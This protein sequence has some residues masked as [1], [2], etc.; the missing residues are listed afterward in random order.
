MRRVQVDPAF[1]NGQLLFEPSQVVASIPS[2]TSLLRGETSISRTGGRIGRWLIVWNE[3]RSNNTTPQLLCGR[4]LLRDGSFDGPSFV[5][6]DDALTT[7]IS[8]FA[9]DGDGENFLVAYNDGDAVARARCIRRTATGPYVTNSTTVYTGLTGAAVTSVA[10][11]GSSV[12]IGASVSGAPTRRARLY[13]VDSYS[14]VSCEGGFDL[15]GTTQTIDVGI[16]SRFDG[17][18]TSSR[19]AFLAWSGN[20]GFVYEGY[21]QRFR[22]DSGSIQ[23]LG[24]GCGSGGAALVSCSRSPVTAPH[25]LRLRGAAPSAMAY[26]ALSRGSLG[27]ACGGGCQLLADPFDGAVVGL[28][29]DA[30]GDAALNVPIGPGLVGQRFVFQWISPGASCFGGFDL[31]NA[32]QVTIQ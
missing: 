18:N 22:T 19:D 16:G 27:I 28:L 9:V 13:S 14:G 8:S 11:M 23:N 30:L 4:F 29:T 6:E 7:S 15:T 1:Q 32:L 25:Y 31:S 10:W 21:A 12:L 17:V 24:G 2:A 5:I 26:L 3:G 20:S